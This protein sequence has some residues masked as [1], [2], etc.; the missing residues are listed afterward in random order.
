MAIENS[1][2]HKDYYKKVYLECPE[3]FCPGELNIVENSA[4]ACDFAL[5]NSAFVIIEI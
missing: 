2:H 3:V 5:W 1:L 4:F